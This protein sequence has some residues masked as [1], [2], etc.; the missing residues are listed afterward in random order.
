[1]NENFESLTNSL[2]LFEP[3]LIES[4]V[5]FL[6]LLNLANTSLKLVSK[7]VICSSSKLSESLTF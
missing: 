7:S 2:E 3:Y 1:M 4:T 5:F 6:S